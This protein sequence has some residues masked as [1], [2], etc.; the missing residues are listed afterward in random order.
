[1]GSGG[2]RAAAGPKGVV[3][4]GE[5]LLRLSSPAG[6]RLRRATSFDV[7]FGGAEANVA[8]AL[9]QWGLPSRYVTALPD[10]DLGDEAVG[11][12][13]ALGVDTSAILRGEG[14]LGLYFLE[15]GSSQRPSRV[16]YDRSGSALA[17]LRPGDVDWGRLLEGASWFHWTGITPALSRGDEELIRGGVRVARDLGLTVSL[18]LNFRSKLWSLGRAREVMGSLVEHVD[19]L[20]GNVG[21]LSAFFG[22][23]DG[24][25]PQRQ[26]VTAGRE[27]ERLASRLVDRFGLD[28]VAVTCREGDSASEVVWG[29]CLHDGVSG[30]QS[31]R[32]RVQ[33]VDGI[34]GG[35]AFSAGLIYGTLTGMDR[36]GALEFGAAAAVLKQTMIGDVLL[37][38]AEEVRGL[39]SGEGGGGILR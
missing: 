20:V 5:T 2:E 39:A 9:A 28:L 24:D 35:D 3:T 13:R 37:A 11:R 26:D 27:C 10:H 4:F 8:A 33:V 32:Y 7:T 15:P 34:G 17:G 21:Q 36:Q 6:T 23:E 38:T 14:R 25:P 29:A 19:V 22:P 31:R 12:L 16:I 30:Y 18:D 1:M